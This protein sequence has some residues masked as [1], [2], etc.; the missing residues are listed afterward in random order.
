VNAGTLLAQPAV[1]L[2]AS[3]AISALAVVFR[4]VTASDIRQEAGRTQNNAG[5]LLPQGVSAM[6]AAMEPLSDDDVF[7]NVGAGIG[8]ILVQ[9]ALTTK[10]R[11]C[12]GVEV[13]DDLCSLAIRHM[14]RHAAAYPLLRKMSMVAADVRHALLSAQAPTSEATIVFAN[15]FLFEET[16]KLFLAR[17]LSAMPN[18]RFVASTARFCSR[19][20][21]WCP[22][23]FCAR[24]QLTHEL[25]AECSWK[26]GLTS[27]YIY[28]KS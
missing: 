27:L 9:V 3:E 28:V 5:E 1:L 12:V 22:Q 13:R 15:Y 14:R 21:A 6:L 16:A 25:N 18:A 11:R 19:H 7:L 8:N 23:P 20:R 26:A 17:E 4:D 24:L 10:V 2:T